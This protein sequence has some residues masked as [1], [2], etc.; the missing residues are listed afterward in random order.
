M[1]HKDGESDNKQC[2]GHSTTRSCPRHSSRH[3]QHHT[4]DH[5]EPPL[6]YAQM[7]TISSL[8]ASWV[9]SSLMDAASDSCPHSSRSSAVSSRNVIMARCRLAA[10]VFPWGVRIFL[11]TCN[12]LSK[13]CCRLLLSLAPP[14]CLA[15]YASRDEGGGDTWPV[16]G[17]NSRFLLPP[18]E[19][20]RAMPIAEIA[21][22]RSASD[23]MS[24][25]TCLTA[26]FGD[27]D[28]SDGA[29]DDEA[30]EAR[31]L[32]KPMFSMTQ[33]KSVTRDDSTP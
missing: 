10:R 14:A 29:V 30:D 20:H 28:D 9:S 21:S 24:R 19:K 1:C 11:C 16:A 6:G 31:L 23:T 7:Q 13:K 15:V 4:T 2:V 25:I 33:N 8:Y 26:T 12:S 18:N 32:L 22:R 3:S 17:Y 27:S 5:I